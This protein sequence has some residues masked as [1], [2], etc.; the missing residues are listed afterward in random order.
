MTA[1][2]Y[3]GKPCPVCGAKTRRKY[4]VGRAAARIQHSRSWVCERGHQLY[5]KGR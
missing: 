3:E 2:K 1:T 4:I 5:R